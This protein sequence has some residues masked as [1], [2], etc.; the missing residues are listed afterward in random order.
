MTRAVDAIA[1]P[2]PTPNVENRFENGNIAPMCER[3][4]TVSYGPAA[5]VSCVA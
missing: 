2:T 5:P 1:F 3:E 4:I